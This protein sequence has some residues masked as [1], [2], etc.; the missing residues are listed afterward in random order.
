MVKKQGRK[1]SLKGSFEDKNGNI[2]AEADGTWIMVNKDIG[3]WTDGQKGRNKGK[4][5]KL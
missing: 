2:L 5:S 1:L 3:R 4:D